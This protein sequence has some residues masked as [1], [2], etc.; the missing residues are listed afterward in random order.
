[1]N[2]LNLF[3]Q[4]WSRFPNIAVP[5]E[6]I[7]HKELADAVYIA[8]PFGKRCFLWFTY[9]Q[10]KN[11]CFV[12]DNSTIYVVQASFHS[13]LSLGTVLF[14]TLVHRN[15]TTCFVMDDIFMLKGAP[16]TC[17]FY[18]KLDIFQSLLDDC[19]CPTR[20]SPSQVTVMLP[21]MAQSSSALNP[22]Y[23]VYNVR[24]VNL[25]GPTKY[26]KLKCSN[27][28][29][30]VKASTKSDTYELYENDVFHSVALVDT[31]KRSV[32]M[33]DLFRTV[34][35]NHNL[36]VIEE[37]ESEDEFENIDPFKHVDLSRTHMME[38]TWNAK[39]KK[40]VPMKVA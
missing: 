24:V 29:F 19:L 1:M 18:T 11:V 31:Y 2:L 35:E 37:S 14:G 34:K 33:N 28:V 8:Q 5:Y 12:V 27:K 22:S 21:Q 26:F 17:S 6:S 32:M 10:S 25:S 38:C 9:H 15:N 36:D 40:W 30:L 7:I 13:S 3:A 23:R 16:I 39:F 4:E 20:Y